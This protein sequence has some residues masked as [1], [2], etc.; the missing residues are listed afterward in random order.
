MN[1][2]ELRTISGIRNDVSPERFD[3]SGAID[4]SMPSPFVNPMIAPG[5]PSMESIRDAT[6][7][8]AAA[9]ASQVETP[10]NPAQARECPH[11]TPIGRWHDC[12]HGFPPWPATSCGAGAG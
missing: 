4:R 1:T 12:E 2:L 8:D 7:I 5:G 10:Q 6:G 11:A 3:R 9:L